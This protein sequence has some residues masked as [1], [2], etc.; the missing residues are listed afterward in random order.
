LRELNHRLL[1]AGLRW[2]P[3]W[4]TCGVRTRRLVDYSS[5]ELTWP[6]SYGD[7]DMDWT[8]GDSRVT[9]TDQFGGGLVAQRGS[10]ARLQH[11]GPQLAQ[12]RWATGKGREHSGMESLPPP[13]S[14]PRLDRLQTQST[15]EHLLPTNY[16]VL[17]AEQL[18]EHDRERVDS[19]H[20]CATLGRNLWITARAVENTKPCDHT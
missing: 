7:G 16:S 3:G 6:P 17:E 18:I 2:Q 5:R 9:Q 1:Y 8:L 10:P 4:V 13:V 14:K 15:G 20:P 19:G 12:S 11:S